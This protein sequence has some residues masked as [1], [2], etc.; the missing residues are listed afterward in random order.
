MTRSPDDK[1]S[2]S[3]G[4][5]SELAVLICSYRLAARWTQEELAA[6]AGLTLAVVAAI[7]DG[8]STRWDTLTKLANAFGFDSFIDLC[9]AG[10]LIIW[11]SGH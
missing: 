4:P 8:H 1:M 11:P 6:K 2:R 5:H 10:E 9:R 7:E 3:P